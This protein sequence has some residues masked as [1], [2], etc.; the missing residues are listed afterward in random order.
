MT[1]KT[2]QGK[3]GKNHIAAM[4]KMQPQKPSIDG[5]TKGDI[6]RLARKGGVKRLAM[7]I[8]DHSKII[9]RDYLRTLL[10]NASLYTAACKRK[11]VTGMD[12]TMA[13]KRLGCSLYGVV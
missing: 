11:T 6:R 3:K 9:M 5:I 13:M 10:K 2:T 4:R 8:Y 12:V 1:E 7:P